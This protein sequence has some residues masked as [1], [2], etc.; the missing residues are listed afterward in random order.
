MIPKVVY[1]SMNIDFAKPGKTDY[2]V[3]VHTDSAWGYFFAPMTAIDSIS[4]AA[5]SE[6]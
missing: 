5:S 2:P 1:N 3:A 6:A 4:G